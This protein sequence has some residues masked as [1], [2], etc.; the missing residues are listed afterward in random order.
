MSPWF[1]GGFRGIMRKLLISPPGPPVE[2]K[3]KD[4]QGGNFSAAE[5]NA[6]A[7]A[8]FANPPPKPVISLIL[9]VL[10]EAPILGGVLSGLPQTPNLEILLV[11][12]GS[13]DATRAVAAGFPHVRCL[14][15]PRGRGVQMNAGARVARG[16]FFIFLHIDT[17]LTTDHL[18]ALCRAAAARGSGPGPSNSA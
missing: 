15:A 1:N 17:V 7:D 13:T 5:E 14:T 16:D 2:K 11:D 12:G 4:R 6:A 18:T 3:E 9:P 10:N 8:D